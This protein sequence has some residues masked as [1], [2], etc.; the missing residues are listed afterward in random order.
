MIR[1]LCCLFCF[2]NLGFWLY[3]CCQLPSYNS[4]PLTLT[5]SL[6]SSP[7]PPDVDNCL[8]LMI[9]YILCHYVT[10][11][12]V[13]CVFH[14]RQCLLFGVH[15]WRRKKSAALS[16]L[17]LWLLNQFQF[18]FFAFLCLSASWVPKTSTNMIESTDHKELSG[19]ITL[20]EFLSREVAKITL[21]EI[22][23][24]DREG[25][26]SAHSPSSRGICLVRVSR[27]ARRWRSRSSEVDILSS[28][29][30]VTVLQ[31]PSG[32][33]PPLH[34]LPHLWGVT[35]L[36]HITKSHCSALLQH[37]THLRVSQWE[38]TTTFNLPVSLCGGQPWCPTTMFLQGSW[39]SC[40]T[41]L[42]SCSRTEP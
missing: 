18:Y 40:L 29:H 9:L 26:L 35:T 24:R 6:F 38:S 20:F 19:Q 16:S 1:V 13:L 27:P 37:H 39:T 8:S 41:F 28:P 33:F 22:E 36:F 32:L 25:R 2:G 17:F 7:I 30:L 15:Q 34:H 31:N 5:W 42:W 21:R 11:L 14:D 12:S 3:L 4:A 10:S 23:E